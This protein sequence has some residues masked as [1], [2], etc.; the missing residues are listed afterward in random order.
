MKYKEK[1]RDDASIT[2]RMPSG[3]SKSIQDKAKSLNMTTSGYLRSI[4]HESH[5]AEWDEL[6][7][8]RKEFEDFMRSI[9]FNKLILWIYSKRNTRRSRTETQEEIRDYIRT[10]KKADQVLPERISMELEKVLRDLMTPRSKYG[11]YSD[12]YEFVKS[13]VAENS[14]DYEKLDAFFLGDGLLDHYQNLQTP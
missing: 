14:I 10:L 4:L 5:S 8:S 7:R 9:E 13:T 3:L 12:E 2:I 1:E 6:K 11:L